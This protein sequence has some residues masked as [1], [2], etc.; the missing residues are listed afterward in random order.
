MQ[1]ADDYERNRIDK[2]CG[3][4]ERVLCIGREEN[5]VGAG[6]HLCAQLSELFLHLELVLLAWRLI[7][8]LR[9]WFRWLHCW[10]LKV[11][12]TGLCKITA[13]KNC[14]KLKFAILTQL[15]LLTN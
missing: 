4:R 6:P 11:S 2:S 1:L 15:N 14:V 9:H 8:A 10:Y 13:M 3:I 5:I 12:V 7:S